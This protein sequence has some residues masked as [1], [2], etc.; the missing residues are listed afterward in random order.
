MIADNINIS[1]KIDASQDFLNYWREEGIEAVKMFQDS[2]DKIRLFRQISQQAV[3]QYQGLIDENS[4]CFHGKWQQLREMFEA[5]KTL[6]E[7]AAHAQL[8]EISVIGED[9]RYIAAQLARHPLIIAGNN[10]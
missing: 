4:D 6:T 1:I 10:N 7:D 5:N 3:A 9:A 8:T 2:V